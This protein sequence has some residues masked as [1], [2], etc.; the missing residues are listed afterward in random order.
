[1]LSSPLFIIAVSSDPPCKQLLVGVGVVFR[2]QVIAVVVMLVVVVVVV[3][4]VVYW[5]H[6]SY[7]PPMSSCSRGCV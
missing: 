2:G 6:S 5:W 7:K 3:V 4:V 1:M